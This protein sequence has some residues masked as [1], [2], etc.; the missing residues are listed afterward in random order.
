[1]ADINHVISL[2]IGSPAAIPEFLTFGLQIGAAVV[3]VGVPACRT[4]SVA[5]ES[6]L[7]SILAETRTIEIPEEIRELPVEC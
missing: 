2:G 3:V 1:M 6:R 5:S 7:I 4:Y